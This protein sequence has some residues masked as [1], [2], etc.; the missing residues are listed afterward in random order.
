MTAIRWVP[1]L[2]TAVALAVHLWGDARGRALP[3][4]LGKALASAGFLLLAGLCLVPDGH[5]LLVLAALALSAAGDL[6]LLGRRQAVFLAGVGA[7]LLAHLAYAAAFA[8]RSHPWPAAAAGLVVLGVLVV[9][10]LWPHLGPLRLPV[11]A[12][13]AAITAMLVLALGVGDPRVRLGAAL[14]YL[15]DLTV[16]RDRFVAPGRW[17]ALLGLPLYYAAQLLLAST[18]GG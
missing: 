4:A 13:A 7:F 6:C 5:G 18:A 14:F 17:N 12:Y 8:P 10:W 1:V 16:A 3:R 11:I 9:R 2:L 15:S